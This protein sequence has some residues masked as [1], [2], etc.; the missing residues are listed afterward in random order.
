VSYHPAD[1]DAA[2]FSQGLKARG[3][4]DTVAEDVVVVDDDVAEIDADAEIDAPLRLHAGITCGNLA[5]HLD[6]ATNRIDHA[7]KFA[8]QTVA[9]RVDDAAAVLL[10]FGVGYLTPQRLQ[11]SE[12][13][14]LVRSHQARIT[15]DVG[16][17]DRC[18]APLDPFLRH[19][20]RPYK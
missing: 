8:E 16:R 1:A 18:Q 3:D 15:R 20:R 9:R 4:I 19:G 2:R 10:D 17:Q 6:R 5:L 14:F 13:A 11:R 7:R 12:R